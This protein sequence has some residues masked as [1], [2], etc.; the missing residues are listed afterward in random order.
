M[1]WQTYTNTFK[2][3]FRSVLFW[4]GFLTVIAVTVHS[5]LGSFESIYDVVSKEMISD[6]D[7]RYVFSY[8]GFLDKIGNALYHGSLRLYVPLIAVVSTFVI[9]HGDYSNG[10]YEIEKAGGVRPA[11]YYFGR[12]T[13]LFTVN[14][15]VLLVVTMIYVHLYTATRGLV[16]G[17]TLTEYLVDSTTRL[18]RGYIYLGF[19]CVLFYVTLTYTVGTLIRSGI[20]GG[21]GGTV[22]VVAHYILVDTAVKFNFPEWVERYI[23]ASPYTVQHYLWFYGRRLAEDWRNH[24]RSNLPEATLGYCITAGCSVLFIVIGY[25]MVRRRTK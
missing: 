19:P 25:L 8:G 18:L 24:T 7:P 15:A 14:C 4:L 1:F 5:T 21:V 16:E 17:L 2:N 6:L 11:S 9:V 23:P 12:L 20:G 3:I 22:Y 13:A 10:F